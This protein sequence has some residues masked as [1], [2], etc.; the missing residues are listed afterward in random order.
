[1]RLHLRLHRCFCKWCARYAKQLDLLHEASQ[2]F[3][4]N[5]DQI[6]GPALDSDSKARMK[7]SL[8]TK[9]NGEL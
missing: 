8:R 7:R 6:S 3:P 1:M 5:L 9:A 2:F 4:E